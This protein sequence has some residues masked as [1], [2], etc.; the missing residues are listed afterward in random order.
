MAPVGFTDCLHFVILTFG[1]QVDASGLSWMP[2]FLMRYRNIGIV[3]YALVALFAFLLMG[4]LFGRTQPETS[5]SL[6]SLHP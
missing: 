6:E 2:L 1:R 5:E 3:G 4:I